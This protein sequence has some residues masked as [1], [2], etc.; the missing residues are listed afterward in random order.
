MIVR[1]SILVLAA[2]LT[3]PL[4][5]ASSA[6]SGSSSSGPSVGGPSGGGSGGGSGSGGSGSGSGGGTNSGS[7][8]GGVSGSG[9]GSGG[10]G[11]GSGSG[12]AAD[13]GPACTAAASVTGVPAYTSITHQAACAQADV[14]A[15]MTACV[16]QGSTT[17]T[18]DTWFNAAANATCAACVQ[19]QNK[20]LTG[21]TI[22]DNQGNPYPNTPGCV[23]IADGNTNCA[24]PLSQFFLCQDDACNSAACNTATDTE[25]QACL[26]QAQKGACATEFSAASPCQADAADGG[27]LDTK[28]G[29]MAQVIYTICGN[30]K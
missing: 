26:D 9:S 16:G 27:T 22:Y 1:R 15:F 4:A 29:T 8:S 14:T 10:T 13:A 25:Y 19:P 12:G 7:G 23:Q 28:C 3:L 30:G 20:A 2:V 24:A 5:T 11:S 6:C 17:A 18:C 21:A